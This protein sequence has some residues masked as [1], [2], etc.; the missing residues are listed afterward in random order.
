MFRIAL[1]QNQSEMAHY[2]YADARPLLVDLGYGVELFTADNID[3]LAVALTRSQFD[4]VVVGSNALNDKTI[5]AETERDSF[6]TAF[7]GWIRKGR[8][9]LCLHQLRLAGSSATLGFL[10]EP[11]SSLTATVRPPGEKSA[12]GILDCGPTASTHT[13]LLYPH[14][15]D[16]KSVQRSAL[17]FRSL[18]GLYWHYWSEV[19]LAEWEELLVDPRAEGGPRAL[20]LAARD[21]L[22]SERDPRAPRVVMSALTLDWQKQRQ[23]L[24]NLLIY[25]VEGRHN[26][27][28]LLDEDNRNTAFDYLIGTLE[29]RRYPFKQY[30]MGQDPGSLVQHLR[31]AVHTVL[32]LG[33]FVAF[34]RLPAELASL[35]R[36][37]VASGHL[38]LIT[39]D[40]EQPVR[41]FSVAGRERTAFRLLQD[42]ELR[43]Q[44]ELRTGYIDGSFWST[45]ETLQT[46]EGLPEARAKYDGLVVDALELASAHDRDGSYDE[47]FGASCA[48][49]W[50]RGRFLG[51]G[52][53]QTVATANWIRA[54]IDKYEAREQALAYL[55]LA[56]LGLLGE[57]EREALV[58]I[59]SGLD[60]TRLS[61]I[62]IVVYL[63]AALAS[64]HLAVVPGLV[65]ALSEKRER[66]G[67]WVD[68][69]TTA[70]AVATLI[71]ALSR[72]R[73][74]AGTYATLKPTLEK[75]IFGGIIHIQEALERSLTLGSHDPSYPWDGKASTTAKCIQAWLR[76]EE[77]VDLPVH[78]LV[79]ALA[80]YDQ[81]ATTTLVGGHALA[82]LEELKQENAC[83]RGDVS[84]HTVRLADEAALRRIAER[85]ARRRFYLTLPSIVL[86]YVIVV[87]LAGIVLHRDVRELGAVGKVAFVDGWAVHLAV[88]ATFA[89]C[90][91]VPWKRWLRRLG[92][93]RDEG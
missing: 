39:T 12:D 81:T 88:L 78:E 55:T 85:K 4:A 35:V 79:G 36:E 30:F 59:L 60:P 56:Q 66:G 43:V 10:P 18:P 9:C 27:A 6:R 91:T 25:V 54:R 47:V 20:L 48:F 37:R 7:R 19:S 29:S 93:G 28:V 90:L 73:S 82:V 21:P 58:G 70:T 76:F 22:I 92:W 74:G 41:R 61:E 24:E 31:S 62:D 44:A 53:R 57:D 63:R 26:T 49:L 16:P 64:E 52:S 1:I 32:V 87:V 72:L 11:L 42:A 68:L 8:G 71:E 15:I 2:G 65:T 50:M 84:T 34:E 89:T 45:A 40:E 77:L 46:L 69:A 17:G 13:L 38:K 5:R 33:P 86:A 3:T 14:K 80:G 23:L 75:M 51:V 83:L 67:A